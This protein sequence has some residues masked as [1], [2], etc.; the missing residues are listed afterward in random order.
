MDVNFLKF[1]RMMP[2]NAL[3][4]KGISILW[5]HYVVNEISYANRSILYL[6]QLFGCIFPFILQACRWS[7]YIVSAWFSSK[8]VVNLNTESS[9]LEAHLSGHHQV[10]IVA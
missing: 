6:I 4:K 8:S 5:K 9:G 10:Y 1:L 7:I 2:M 3:M